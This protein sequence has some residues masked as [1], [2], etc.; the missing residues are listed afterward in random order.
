[1]GWFACHMWKNNSNWYGTLSC[2][3][4]CEIFAVYTQFTNVTAGRIIKPGGPHL[5]VHGVTNSTNSKTATASVTITTG[6]TTLFVCLILAQ[7][8]PPMDQGLIHKVYR[9]HTTHHRR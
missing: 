2:L 3:N 5:E 4:Y 7:E 1:M 6:I 8:P 9:S